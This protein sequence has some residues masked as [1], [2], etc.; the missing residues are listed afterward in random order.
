MNHKLVKVIVI[1]L[2]SSILYTSFKNVQT[3]SN[4]VKHNFYDTVNRKWI[5]ETQLP[6]GARRLSALNEAA[7][8]TNREVD[9]LLNQIS[10]KTEQGT[11]I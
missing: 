9:L 5:E 11:F 4:G 3:I 1:S 8:H 6:I 7:N 2:I 10:Q